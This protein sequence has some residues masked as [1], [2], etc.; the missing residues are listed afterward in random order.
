[1]SN[2][3]PIKHHY[4]Q[5]YRLDG[6]ATKCKNGKNK[7]CILDL[8]NFKAEYRNTESAMYTK[9]LY[10]VTGEDV[11]TLE[12]KMNDLIE[13]PTNQILD[14]LVNDASKP[15][16]LT[17]KEL[18]IIKKYILIQIFRNR[19]N[20]TSYTNPPKD[21]IELSKYNISQGESKLDFWK[22]EMDTILELE[23]NELVNSVDLVSVRKE[24]VALHTGF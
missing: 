23:W 1:M 18:C 20:M 10:D 7:V 14:R 19:R 21:S 24:A 12:R 16:V 22:R 11:A 4:V 15:I 9:H 2:N 8:F 3:T 13:N 5:K 6:F 17:R